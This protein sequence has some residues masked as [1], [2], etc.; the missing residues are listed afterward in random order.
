M[1]ELK[2]GLRRLRREL[3]MTQM[4]LATR[5]NISFTT[6]S[7]WENKHTIPT[8]AVA[9]AV[10][11]KIREMDVSS[12]CIAYLEEAFF[13]TRDEEYDR[14]RRVD[15]LL[16]N[17]LLNES[18]NGIV[19]SDPD[20]YELLYINRTVERQRGVAAGELH[21]Q[22]CYEYLMERTA[23]CPGCSV[24]RLTADAFTTREVRFPSGRYYSIRGKLI[25]WEGRKAHI[26]YLS[27]ITDSYRAQETL[28]DLTERIPCGMAI[29]YLDADKNLTMDYSNEGFCVLLG[30]T[31]PDCC[32]LESRSLLEIVHDLDRMRLI[33]E[34]EK[35]V[36]EKR[37][38]D[39]EIRLMR[40]DG[41]F[42][43]CN[44]QGAVADR[45]LDKTTFYLTFFDI[46]RRKQLRDA[47]EES[48]RAVEQAAEIGEFGLWKY[49]LDTRML[50]QNYTLKGYQGTPRETANVPESVIEQKLVH[51]DDAEI[52]RIFYQEILDGKTRS[53]C[54][55]RVY[56]PN[57]KCYGLLRLVLVRQPD[58]ED[59][60]RIAIGFCL[61][62]NN[63][64]QDTE[65]ADC[66]RKGT[67]CVRRR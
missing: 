38:V 51:P 3:N 5:L 4:E 50:T 15:M 60:T 61:N 24:S 18:A 10:M 31:K 42:I 29:C 30:R 19:V 11:M 66:I 67:I 1:M 65:N 20:T 25:E 62:M 55:V 27:D 13:P 6:L 33:G 26:E 9:E 46:D 36:E 34:L 41:H 35:A 2:A 23:P 48:R 7:R 21:G 43:W 49:N 40:R 45:T 28:R 39:L 56:K 17:Q 16:A 44:M 32:C 53:E 14:L 22:K 58:A 47:L 8:P 52:Y 37:G 12:S 59:G 63:S 64:R 54:Q 57:E